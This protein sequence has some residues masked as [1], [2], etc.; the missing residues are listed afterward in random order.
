MKAY[1]KYVLLLALLSPCAALATSDEALEKI[2]R[3][4]LSQPQNPL[5]YLKRGTYFFDKHQYDKALKDYNRTLKLVPNSETAFYNRGNTYFQ[6]QKYSLA[7]KDFNQALQL[8]PTYQQAYYNRG[9]THYHLKDF[10]SALK[11][12]NHYLKAHPQEAKAYVARGNAFHHAG[13]NKQA[14]EDYSLALKLDPTQSEAL[15]NRGL[16]HHNMGEYAK[17]KQDYLA[18]LAL[19]ESADTLGRLSWTALFLKDAVAAKEAAE[20]G[21]KVNPQAHWIGANLGHAYLLLGE[22]SAAQHA[23]HQFVQAEP[24]QKDTL[25]QDYQ[26][27]KKAGVVL[28]GFESVY[29]TL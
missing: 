19:R 15:S 27:L 24:N 29:Q 23:Y 26:A 6:L 3:E 16:T 21:L 5:L 28:P 25:M 7:L 13:Q 10:Q 12:F 4:I 9:M 18:S 2:N 11:D 1:L 22:I 14:L 8:A 17:A 20:K